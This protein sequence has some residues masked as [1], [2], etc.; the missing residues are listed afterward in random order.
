MLEIKIRNLAL[1]SNLEIQELKDE[2]WDRDI[3]F[4]SKIWELPSQKVDNPSFSPYPNLAWLHRCFLLQH[5][6]G[7]DQ[8]I[9]Q[10][11]MMI[12]LMLTMKGLRG[13]GRPWATVDTS[14][15]P[16]LQSLL[17]SLPSLAPR[18]LACSGGG[19]ERES[20]CCKWEDEWERV[21]LAESYPISY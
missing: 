7:V 14:L 2:P 10:E 11:M 12:P 3:T 20:K 21:A 8:S 1:R 9:I 15:L 6:K 19:R 13:G 16:L 17:Q 4:C 18:V 5:T